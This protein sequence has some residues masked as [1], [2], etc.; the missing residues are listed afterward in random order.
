M[1][2]FVRFKIFVIALVVTILVVVAKYFLHASGIEPIEQTSIHNGVVSSVIFVVGFVLSATI[3]DYKESERIPAD[4]AAMIQDMFE[5]AAE[6]KKTHQKFDLEHFRKNLIDI[7]ETF[8]E[9]TRP[10]RRGAR[11]DINDL[12]VTFGEMERAGVPANF[13]VKLKQQQTQLLRSMYRVNYI[14][15]I[16]FMPSASILVR[17]IVVLVTALLLLTNIDPFFG[18]LMIVGFITFIMMYMVLLIQVISKPFRPEGTTQDDVSLFLL[19]ET[20]DHLKKRKV[21]KS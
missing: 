18:G 15:K 6:I 7:L 2:L 19:R 12:H 14:Q 20:I 11:E 17:A 21:K 1:R 8:R 9:G 13:I 4:F 16:N 10:K 3:T 5:D